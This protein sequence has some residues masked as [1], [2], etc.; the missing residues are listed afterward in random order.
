VI[1]DEKAKIK[2]EWIK[3]TKKKKWAEE[4]DKKMNDDYMVAIQK[5]LTHKLFKFFDK[6]E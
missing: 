5:R 1:I 4:D 3:K 2:N 6:F